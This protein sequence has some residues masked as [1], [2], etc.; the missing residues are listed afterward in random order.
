MVDDPLL[1]VDHLVQVPQK[2]AVLKNTIL[3][4]NWPLNMQKLR[5][6]YFLHWFQ[7]VNLD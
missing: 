3:F 6:K 4:C 2:R 1:Q 5:Q 7:E